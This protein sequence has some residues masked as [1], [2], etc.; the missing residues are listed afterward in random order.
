MKA[1]VEKEG[2]SSGYT[3]DSAGILSIHQ[4][5]KAD[6]RMRQ[7][8]V[9][10]GYEIT[11]IS[12]PVVSSDFDDFDLII[13][14][15]DSNIDDLKDRALT[16]EHVNKISKM[17]DY[18]KKFRHHTYVPDPYYGGTDGFELVL[19]LL[20]DACIGLLESLKSKKRT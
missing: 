5:E 2:L 4:G 14:M 6:I 1:L 9:R 13:G 11:S 10:R 17:T 8:A 16:Q 20:E 12:R 18:C 3:I 19:D 7:H 15:D